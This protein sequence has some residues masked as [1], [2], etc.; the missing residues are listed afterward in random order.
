LDQFVVVLIDDILVYSRTPEEHACH[1]REVLGVLRRNKLYVKLTKCEFWL[2]KVTFLAHVVS[3]EGI[4]VGPQKIE[5][6]T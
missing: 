5:V 3:K 2:E 6:V 1:L 4:F